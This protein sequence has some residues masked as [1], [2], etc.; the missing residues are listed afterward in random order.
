MNVP[1]I[2][3]VIPCYNDDKYI[4]QAINSVLN[5]TYQNIEI[6]VVDDGSNIETKRVLSRLEAKVTKLINQENKGQ[7]TARN[8]GIKAAKGEYIL[9]LDSDDFFEPL[10]CEKAISIF[11]NKQKTKIVS[12]YANIIYP[13]GNR[14]LYKPA[15][16]D[17]NNVIFNNI[18]LGSVMFKKENWKIA[19]GY[20]ETMRNGF[21]DWEFYIRMLREGGRVLIIKEPLFNY[22]RQL[23]STTTKAN[24]NKYELLKYIYLKHKSLYVDNFELLITHLLN[25]IEREELEKVKKEKSIEYKTGYF[26]LRPIRFIKRL[27]S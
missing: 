2:S 8:V 26:L 13:T 4:E 14:E 22:R 6:I 11:K 9:I 24:R 17:I 10:F 5:Q 23:N 3:I 19:Q 21:E 12:C 16:G 27:L 1:V 15:G 25:K 7:S 20:D 18:A